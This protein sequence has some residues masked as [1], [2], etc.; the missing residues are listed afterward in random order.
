MKKLVTIMLSLILILGL[1]PM[2]AFAD[3]QSV[4]IRTSYNTTVN[5]GGS[6]YLSVVSKSNTTDGYKLVIVP[7]DEHI[8]VKSGTSGIITSTDEKTTIFELKAESNAMIGNHKLKIYAYSTE[9]D[10][11][12]QALEEQTTSAAITSEQ[13]KLLQ[14]Y[15][16]GV[17]VVDN[18]QSANNGKTAAVNVSY[19]LS[20]GDSIYADE[21]NTITVSFY[22]RGTDYLKN[23]ELSISLPSG[24]K[25]QSG[26][27]S[28]YVGDIRV[29]K[30]AEA[31]FPII[32]DSTITDTSYAITAKLKGYVAKYSE[33][34]LNEETGQY[35][36]EFLGYEEKSLSQTF[37]VPVKNGASEKKTE[38]SDY[39]TPRLMVSNYSC[40]GS[41]IAGKTF[42]LS[43]T[44]LNTSNVTL[45]NIKVT[46]E[47]PTGMVPVGSSSSFFIASLAAGET[48]SKSVSLS[49]GRDMVQAY[50]PITVS[51]NYEDT[52]KAAYTTTD[53]VSASVVQE[54]RLV[55]DD[56]LDPGW[57]TMS[58]QGY[59]S[60]N[61]R[62]M[63]NTD[64][65]NL[66]IAI[67][68]DFTMDTA[69]TYFVGTLEAGKQDYYSFNFW[70]NQAGPMTGRVT[71]IYED[72][73]GEE[74]SLV[75]EMNFNIGEA[76]S[77][78]DPG[79]Y[80]EPI[81]EGFHMPFWGWIIIAVVAIVVLIVVIKLIKKNKA[82]KEEALDLDE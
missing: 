14:E 57:L 18:Q 72:A 51:M 6:N 50:Y 47:A 39:A 46:V 36:S 5:R 1:M 8:K 17:M 2:T 60:V 53:T 29:N 77:Y 64:I 71:F 19:A 63:G 34:H 37:Y 9:V 11:V 10:A 76:Y 22:N 38:T 80:E 20:G 15:E 32:C 67:E 81:E 40:G 56:I 59:A 74:H 43:L 61:F 4:S 21:I 48:Y 3:G 27:D 45:Q 70:P 49:T 31:S 55:V 30:T 73:N 16:F 42:G 26:P 68:G 79:M 41:V 28:M 23:A 78:D 13:G 66:Q 35:E 12:G 7:E 52:N 65:K 82:K 54:S 62:N 44:L 33:A 25:I 24:M 75:K 58:D 69:S